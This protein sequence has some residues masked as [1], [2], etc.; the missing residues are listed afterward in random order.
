VKKGHTNV[1]VEITPLAN[2]QRGNMNKEQK[3][4]INFQAKH[5]A[6]KQIDFSLSQAPDGNPYWK[7]FYNPFNDF[8]GMCSKRELAFLIEN[9]RGMSG[10]WK[11]GAVDEI[12][13]EGT[14]N[15]IGEWVIMKLQFKN[16]SHPDQQEWFKSLDNRCWLICEN[17]QDIKI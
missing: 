2:N 6:R 17:G 3:Q 8:L 12:C 10:G 15:Q 11:E 13:A 9:S 1:A 16:N 5:K 7:K 4:A 14:K